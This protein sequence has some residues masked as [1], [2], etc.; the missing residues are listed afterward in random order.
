MFRV[1]AKT[2][3]WDEACLAARNVEDQRSDAGSTLNF[4]RDLITLRRNSGDLRDGEYSEVCV[5]G[6]MWV[7][8][9]GASTYVA[10]NLGNTDAHV[11]VRGTIAISTNRSRD[12]ADQSKGL[13]LGP[14]EGVV[15]V[16]ASH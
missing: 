12:G 3:S 16:A 2:T 15:L 4:V 11:D 10:V 14:R 1:S 5:R 9:R 8:R 7:W 13:T 6:D